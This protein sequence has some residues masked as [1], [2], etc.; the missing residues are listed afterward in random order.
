MGNGTP[1]VGLD[2]ATYFIN[3][4]VIAGALI[5]LTFIALQLFMVDMLTR[6]EASAFPVFRSRE[7]H[8]LRFRPIRRDTPAALTD[9]ELLDGDPL[10]V[11]MAFSI[12]VSWSLF[13]L[14]LVIGLTAAWNKRPGLLAI[15]MFVFSLILFF[16]FRVRSQKVNQL[17]PYLTREEL[18][19][20]LISGAAFV[21]Y[22]VTGLV[23]LAA[24]FPAVVPHRFGPSSWIWFGSSYGED[25]AFLLKF[26]CIAS[27]VLGT[28]TVNKDMFIFFKSASAERMR[29]CWLQEFVTNIYPDLAARIRALESKM[30]GN[31]FDSSHLARRWRYGPASISTHDSFKKGDSPSA[32][33]LWT[34]LISPP[35]DTESR[36]TN[37]QPKPEPPLPVPVWLLDVPAI[38]RWVSEIERELKHA[39]SP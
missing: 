10:V 23:L 2:E 27:L 16:N 21:L 38:A 34:A 29:Q 37:I 26:S 31:T 30:L 32:R 33:G 15:E 7:N 17:N 28:Y 19:W 24:A 36:G 39:E 8:K 6:F 3:V 25:A 5:G 35:P 4:A 14:P 18:L 13:L 22:V 1:P 9:A 12:A 11:F 20:P